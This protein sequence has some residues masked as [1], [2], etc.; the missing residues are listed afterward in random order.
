MHGLQYRTAV[1]VLIQVVRFGKY[2]AFVQVFVS[3]SRSEWCMRRFE[4]AHQEERL[5]LVRLLH[6]IDTFV[7]D[8]IRT[9]TFGAYG[10]FH[11][12]RKSAF[13]KTGIL[14]FAL[15]GHDTVEVETFGLCADVPFAYDG[16][17][18]TVLLEFLCHRRM[19]GREFIGEG[20]YLVMMTVLPRQDSRPAGSAD[21]IG[22]KAVLHLD[23]FVGYTVDIGSFHIVFQY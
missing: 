18:I 13:H 10:V 19:S 8:D 9:V 4:V 1:E 3:L 21:G 15:S 17:L 7:R 5:V 6:P 23:A 22:D 16:S 12:E 2:N 14:V 20:I 11:V